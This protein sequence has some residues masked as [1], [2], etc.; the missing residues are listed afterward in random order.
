MPRVERLSVLVVSWNG[1]AHLETC[2]PA[3]LAQRGV[4][5]EVEIL[6][7]D[8]GST[9]GTAE[10]VRSRFPAV[11]LVESAANLGFAAGNNRL[12][13]V[14]SGD[15]LAL[16]NNDTR[17]EPGWLAA[18]VDAYRAAD[19]DVAAVAGRI[20]DWEGERLDFGRGILAF[21]GHALPLDQ[22]RPLAF[23][24]SPAAGE[25][26]LFGCG[27]NLLVG[28]GAFRAA[29]GFDER[30][31]AYFE[32]VDLGWRLWAGGERVVA[33]PEAVVRHRLSATSAR[34][35]NRSRGALFERN[36]LWTV[37]KNLESG[38]RERLLPVVLLTFLSR[39]EAMLVEEGGGAELLRGEASSGAPARE[40]LGARLRRHGPLGLARRG[41]C[42][43]LRGLAA[44]VTPAGSAPAPQLRVAGDRALAQL[45]ALGGFLADLEAVERDHARLAGRRRRADREIF[46]RFPLWIVP[47]YPGDERL[48]ASAAFASW[49][50]S[51]L[52]FER[53]ALDEVLGSR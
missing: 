46:E 19:P 14:A 33:C 38:L 31:F 22:G 17:A 26:L 5:A 25:E 18:L 6:V 32:D 4:A 24:R 10:L 37:V 15:A 36:A 47:A 50:P 29:G 16:V 7:L 53:A 48:F 27:G 9:D 3:L 2:L 45:G 52:R 40:P 34:L 43:A 12:A 51:E 8:N 44:A 42:K 39:L 20:V 21:D 35:G 13:A 23:A 28:A 41:V 1:R 11:R 49:L 30:F